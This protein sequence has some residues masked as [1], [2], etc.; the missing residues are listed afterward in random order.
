MLVYVLGKY[1]KHHDGNNEIGQHCKDDDWDH[2][3]AALFDGFV[4]LANTH[5]DSKVLAI[6]VGLTP[7]VLHASIKAS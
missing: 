6:S 3:D 5:S 1:A 4:V 2:H 7:L